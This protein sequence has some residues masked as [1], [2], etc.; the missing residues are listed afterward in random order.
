MITES[1]SDISRSGKCLGLLGKNNKRIQH[2]FG[3]LHA[4]L[5]HIETGGAEQESPLEIASGE[6]VKDHDPDI[7]SIAVNILVNF[8]TGQGDDL[9]PILPGER[10]IPAARQRQDATIHVLVE[11]A[12]ESLEYEG[13]GIPAND[14]IPVLRF[15][16]QICVGLVWIPDPETGRWSNQ[17]IRRLG[18]GGAGKLGGDFPGRLLA[19][20][21]SNRRSL[22]SFRFS[23]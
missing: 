7:G 22:R 20:G 17:G 6:G 3:G 1:R 14:Q 13:L 12:L 18:G 4:S 19:G 21:G 9:R 10:R 11:E 2:L 16:L 5:G 8:K 23:E 15:V